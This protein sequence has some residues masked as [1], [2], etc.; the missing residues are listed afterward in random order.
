MHSLLLLLL[1]FGVTYS[2]AELE[3]S[4]LEK[5]KN[6]QYIAFEKENPIQQQDIR[7]VECSGNLS[8]V[9][10]VHGY[11]KISLKE[12][13][14]TKDDIFKYRQ[15][16][17]CVII[18]SWLYYSMYSDKS[19]FEDKST[20]YHI[21]AKTHVRYL[22]Q[23]VTEKMQ[24]VHR[25]GAK[26]IELVGHSIGAHAVGQA[27]RH[28]KQNTGQ[29]VDRIIA[30]D[31]AST[32]FKD[33]PQWKLRP[34]DAKNVTVFHTNS[35]G[36]GLDEKIGTTDIFV[37]GGQ[38]QPEC[39]RKLTDNICSHNRGW[40]VFSEHLKN[41]T[42]DRTK[43]Q[44]IHSDRFVLCVDVSGSM[45]KH[46][47][48]TRAISSGTKL[49]SD[50]KVGSYIGIAVF[51]S[52]AKMLQDIIQI[53]GDKDRETLISKLPK[54]T[55]GATSIGAGL[56]LSMQMLQSLPESDRFCSTII[57][58]SDGKQN[59]EP[60]PEQILPALQ[61]ACIG[62][63]SVALGAGASAGLEHLSAQTGGKVILAMES[64][65][66]QQ[67]VDTERAFLFSY[68][69]QI[70][71]DIRPIYLPTRQVTLGD[72][73]SVIK[74]IIDKNVGKDTEFTF[75]SEDSKHFDVKLITPNGE[76]YTSTSPEYT[77]NASNLQKMFKIPLAETGNWG[78]VVRKIA[79]TR[80]SIRSTS[81]AI[82]TVKSHRLDHDQPP[83]R[84]DASLSKRTLEYPKSNAQQDV[85]D[86]RILIYAELRRGQY[87][88]INA[89]VLGHI[90]G[91]NEEPITFQLRDDGSFPD[92]LANDGVY[93]GSIIK[94]KQIQRYS[95]HVSA[96][97]PNE[98]ARL[99]MREID[100]FERELID[101]DRITCETVGQ[102]EREDYVGS[103][104]LISKDNEDH[105]PPNPVT[106]LRASVLN[107]TERIIVL[108]WTSPGDDAF[109]VQVKGY[110][111]RAISGKYFEN[112]FIF[113]DSHVVEASHFDRK[114]KYLL[115]VPQPMWK[116]DKKF[117]EPG[118]FLEI[119][120]AVKAI[121]ANGEMAPSSNLASVVLKDKPVV[122]IN[123]HKLCKTVR[124]TIARVGV[125][126]VTRC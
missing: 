116:Y 19:G 90:Q 8:T 44:R 81:N 83:I 89:N 96:T 103:V 27:A 105:I 66:A 58:L 109:D 102:F 30:L 60:G 77:E 40:D 125:V 80:R 28:F 64:N 73:E 48:L 87:P 65:D 52:D 36:Y 67:I 88:I 16:V 43:S 57:L 54:K 72:G 21:I 55:I 92:E 35:G 68:E 39:K 23:D 3:Q 1:S 11:F 33:N 99:V 113:N 112:A 42:A 56:N 94:L 98:T 17:K 29:E 115:R 75:T 7:D 61:K 100:Y 12:P 46:N 47:R 104:K 118:F 50:M 59:V 38:K 79:K 111:I 71:S 70:D 126:T 41:S 124:R 106:D 86:A 14:N 20:N 93:T 6:V 74:F 2:Y 15:D 49:F 45:D 95:V 122:L 4:H 51:S 120:F 5:Y 63:N 13:L 22:A 101:C 53:T 31:P 69:N 76:T 32:Y 62:V 9:F 97:N 37:N 18:V 117:D 119:T 110:D 108:E 91:L 34:T 25:N 114:E 85:D 121:G 10:I 24:Y 78:L 82:V 26:K 123:A 84:L 107:E